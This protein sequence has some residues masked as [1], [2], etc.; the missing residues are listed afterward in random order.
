MSN[1]NPS[2][3][4]SANRQPRKYRG[5]S[6][7]TMIIEALKRSSRTQSDI[8]DLIVSRAFESEGIGALQEMLKRL[9]PTPKATAPKIKFDF[10]KN[11][12]PDVQAVMIL[13]AISD[14]VIAPDI[15]S[16]LLNSIKSLL[17]IQEVT[18][19]AKRIED[20]EDFLVV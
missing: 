2:N 7:A 11:A 1:K 5:K 19:L 12:T 3:Q 15:G 9:H 8:Y 20:L 10:D 17:E 14:G 4:F 18:V 16:M 13:D 6:E